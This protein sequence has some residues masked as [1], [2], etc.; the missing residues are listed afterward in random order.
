LNTFASNS[1]PGLID[2]LWSND[3]T[4]QLAIG[5]VLVAFALAMALV[6][7]PLLVRLWRVRSLARV[8]AMAAG[9]VDAPAESQRG[10]VQ[11]TF[12]DSPLEAEWALFLQR[13]RA[14]LTDGA[15]ERSPVRFLDVLE[16]H[17]LLPTGARRSLLPALPSLFLAIGLLGTFVGLGL[18]LSGDAFGGAGKSVD[19]ALLTSHVG[20]SLRAALWG[21][22]LSIVSGV[23]GRLIDGAFEGVGSSLDR[24]VQRC[25]PLV[26]GSELTSFGQRAQHEAL[27]ALGSELARFTTD[28]TERLDRGLQRIE[29]STANAASLVSEEQRTGVQSVIRDLALQVRQ[30]VDEHLSGLN[31]ALE[32]ATEHQD[33]VTGGI[34]AAFNQMA[35]QSEAHARVTQTLDA[36][37]STVEAASGSFQ[38]TVLDFDPVLT[39]LR[40][41][42]RSLESTSERIDS[43]HGVMS[44]AAEDV[45]LSLQHA[46]SAVGEQRDFVEISLGEIRA[47][48]DAL[49]T[50]L[51]ENLAK[52]LRAVDDTLGQTVGRLRETIGESNDTIERMSVPMRAAEG[53]AREFHSALERARSEL[54]GLSDWL[55]QAMKPVRSSLTQLDERTSDVARAMANFGDHAIGMDKTMD[56]MRGD[57]REEGRKFRASTADLSRK[58]TSTVEALVQLEHSG[59]SLDPRSSR[60]HSSWPGDSAPP[61]PPV[62]TVPVSPSE[63]AATPLDSPTPSPA[64]TLTPTP[65]PTPPGDSGAPPISREALRPTGTPL[66][67]EVP[68]AAAPEVATS[69]S[70]LPSASES[71]GDRSLSPFQL[72]RT[73]GPGDSGADDIDEAS[74]RSRASGFLSRSSASDSLRSMVAGDESVAGRRLGPDPYSRKEHAPRSERPLAADLTPDATLDERVDE[75][76]LSGLLGGKGGEPTIPPAIERSDADPSPSPAADDEPER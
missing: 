71:Q 44:Q 21:I 54:T 23:V 56:A 34:A 16:E 32:R 40:D 55:A 41:T 22:A 29:R 20:L 11:A 59:S 63:T 28:L 3:P 31:G 51:G 52:S 9:D 15:E 70:P 47:T 53:T 42:G 13:W 57:L 8:V 73:P 43:T 68:R 24:S 69:E 45:R 61:A 75:L 48:L 2:L 25:F 64:L 7:V 19:V 37:A 10:E 36:A 50:G 17:P 60:P 33:T 30:G 38:Q 49:S 35:D 65:T 72:D 1:A 76:S 67:P 12:S 27:V 4:S 5:L 74:R 62:E 66:S 14:A 18:A 26:S 6:Y 58:L 46:A 39:Q